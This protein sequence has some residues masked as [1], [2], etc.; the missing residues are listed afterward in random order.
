ML[1]ISPTFFLNYEARL[2]NNN[3]EQ[4]IQSKLTVTSCKLVFILCAIFAVDQLLLIELFRIRS[5]CWISVQLLNYKTRLL[6]NNA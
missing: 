5:K 1:D 3:A 6:N 2:L 4:F